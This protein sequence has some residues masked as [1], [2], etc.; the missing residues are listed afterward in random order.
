[1]GNV[2]KIFIQVLKQR[3]GHISIHPFL[4]FFFFTAPLVA[5]DKAKLQLFG[6]DS[7]NK[8]QMHTKLC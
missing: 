5:G 6:G 4:S 2:R 3:Y 1:M 8:I 7:G